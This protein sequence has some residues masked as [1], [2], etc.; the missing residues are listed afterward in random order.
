[1]PGVSQAVQVGLYWGS[2][3]TPL[4]GKLLFFFKHAFKMSGLEEFDLCSSS[5]LDKVYCETDVHDFS[6]MRAGRDERAAESQHL[7]VILIVNMICLFLDKNATCQ[8]L[9]SLLPPHTLMFS[10]GTL[11][12]PLFPSARRKCVYHL[13]DSASQM[14]RINLYLSNSSQEP[15]RNKLKR[16]NT[17]G[18]SA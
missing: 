14:S 11:K 15:A 9:F 5:S 8:V 13:Q 10:C 17:G 3:V 1:M 2:L 4:T 12:H 18:A 16:S 6:K 7:S